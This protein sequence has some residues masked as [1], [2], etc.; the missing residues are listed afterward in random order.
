[1]ALKKIFLITFVIT[2]NTIVYGQKKEKIKGDRNVT[3]HETPINSFNKIIVGENFNIDI[4]EGEKALVFVE[5]DD[6]LHEVIKF[7]VADS[8]LNFQTSKKITSSKQLTIKVIYTKTLKEIETVENGEL[9]SLTS[10]NLDNVSLKNSGTSRAFLNVKSKSFKLSSSERSKVK[11]NLTSSLSK[12]ELSDNSKLDALIN[13]DTMAIDLYQRA[14]AKVRGNIEDLTVR[15]DNS[16]NLE[17]KE[18][19]S[20]N[21]DVL[22]ES[23]SDVSINVTNTLTLEVSG[24]GEIFIYD[25]PKITINKFT[26]TAKLHKK[27]LKK[28]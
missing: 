23:S 26:N 15:A 24:S 7:N 4:I 12:F 3:I 20:N 18:L 5:T 8:T 21:C 14:N 19:V 27:E 28:Q 25:E 11:L 2:C 1:M 10:I 17:G 22:S 13:A 16:S 6:N 9:S